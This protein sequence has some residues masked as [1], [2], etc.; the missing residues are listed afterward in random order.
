MTL[1][2]N[3][4]PVLPRAVYVCRPVCTCVRICL[5]ACVHASVWRMRVRPAHFSKV[6]WAG[7]LFGIV[8]PQS[9]VVKLNSP[10]PH[11]TNVSSFLFLPRPCPSSCSPSGSWP[12]DGQEMLVDYPQTSFLLRVNEVQKLDDLTHLDRISQI[13][14][15]PESLQ[16]GAL[17]CTP[18]R[19]S[20]LLETL[21]GVLEIKSQ[22]TNI[23]TR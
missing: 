9:V 4:Q 21:V 6:V 8:N 15:L 23:P 18:A 10:C 14:V 20:A 13:L 12:V 17:S 3:Q 1:I 5:H 11:G 22:R 2:P 19:W 16:A 7:A